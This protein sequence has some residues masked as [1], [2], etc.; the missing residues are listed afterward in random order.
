MWGMALCISRQLYNQLLALAVATAPNE[1]CGLLFGRDGHIEELIIADNVAATRKTH[2]EI[3]PAALI[4][5]EKR[6]RA[7]GAGLLGYFHS[8]PS[9]NSQP[10]QTD[11]DMA[12]AD[13]RYWLIIAEQSISAWRAQEKGLLHGRF[14]P[15]GLD[16]RA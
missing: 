3:D 6:A 12:A 1:C 13:G 8:H 16:S 7:G 14:T 11:A 15:V 5:A 9:G 2:F 4:A 10:S